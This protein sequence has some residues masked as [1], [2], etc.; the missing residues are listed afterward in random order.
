MTPEERE[1]RVKMETYGTCARIAFEDGDSRNNASWSAKWHNLAS[2]CE[3]DRAPDYLPR[4]FDPVND[5][6]V[7]LDGEHPNR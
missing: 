7:E 3:A 6:P 1:R 2:E 5:S 4:P